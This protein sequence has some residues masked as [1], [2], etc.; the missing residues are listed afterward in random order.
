MAAQSFKKHLK[1]AKSPIH[2]Y[3]CFARSPIPKGSLIGHCRTR[4]STGHGMYTLSLPSGEDVDV[5]CV[6]RYINHSST[7]NCVYYDD[8]SVVAIRD[9][10]EGDELLHDYE[11]E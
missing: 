9:I 10:A 5:T 11:S 7:P 3:G 6:L 1:K 2:G 4:P 8:L